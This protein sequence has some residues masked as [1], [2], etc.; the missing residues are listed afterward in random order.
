ML[1]F[2]IF[3]KEGSLWHRLF[4]FPHGCPLIEAKY[5]QY[6]SVLHLEPS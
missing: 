6:L 4:I 1:K 2:P 3:L 5:G